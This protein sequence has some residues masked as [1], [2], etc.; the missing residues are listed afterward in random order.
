MPRTRPRPAGRRPARAAV[1]DRSW[2]QPTPR[3]SGRSTRR[4]ATIAAMTDT[5][6]WDRAAAVATVDG[7]R[8]P[9]VAALSA[10]LTSVVELFDF[11]RDAESRFATLRLRIE[12]RSQTARG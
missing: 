4:D 6:L 8:R 12:E 10:E 5:R 11:M 2:G 9:A 1:V 3:A 7:R